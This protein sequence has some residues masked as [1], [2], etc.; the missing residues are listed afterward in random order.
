MSKV[1]SMK[2]WAVYPRVGGATLGLR[3]W[4]RIGMGL[5]PRGRGNQ[6]IV[7][8]VEA[9]ERS[10]PAWAGQPPTRS[11]VRRRSKVYPRVGGATT[12][13][14]LMS[15]KTQGLS[16]RGR[17]NHGEGVEALRVEGSIP[18]WAGQP[19]C[20]GVPV[21][22]TKVYPRVGGATLHRLPSPPG[23]AGLSPRGR[24]NLVPVGGRGA[25]DRSIPA[26]A[27]QPR[28][29]L[30]VAINIRVYP[31]VGGATD[32][33]FCYQLVA[34][35]LSPRGR[36]NP[37]AAARGY[38]PAGS[39]PAWAG[40]PTS[41]TTSACTTGVYPRV[42]GATIAAGRCAATVDGLSPRGRGNLI[43]PLVRP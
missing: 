23:G 22:I 19:L 12:W 11:L 20:A 8:H 42:G 25:A 33:A 17:G 21:S 15:N 1:R 5:S 28:R 39:I 38:R 24:G 18:A 41:T 4:R 43:E 35:G 9:P 36:G 31:R 40:Q 7:S 2:W 6:R 26:W 34:M 30:R 10:I 32:I 29:E 27:G 37:A 13:G 16:P 14:V 3:S